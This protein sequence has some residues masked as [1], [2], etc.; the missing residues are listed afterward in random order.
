MAI[1]IYPVIG[2]QTDL[3]FYLSGIGISTPEYNLKRERGLISHQLF[4]TK[5]GTG[6]LIVDGKTFVQK[7]GSI[8][9]MS[10]KI[11]HEYIRATDDWETYWIVF[12]GKHLPELM[13]NLGFTSYVFNSC[14]SSDL[15]VT[16]FN[17]I[18]TAAKDPI[19]GDEKSSLLLYEYILYFKKILFSSQN[20]NTPSANILESAIIYMNTNFAS[21]I[22]LQ[23]LAD[24]SHISLQHFCRLFKAQ[25]GMRP[26]EYLTRRR[27]SEAKSLLETTDKPIEEIAKLSGYDDANYF[28]IVF[29]KLEGVSPS[30]Y[31]L[32]K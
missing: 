17:R 23:D 24:C 10:P 15:P 22:T 29:K 3:P 14:N 5:K 13:K 27:I 11:P 26:I 6:K 20:T 21:Y 9:Y 4:F 31:R 30:A 8:F 19:S 7:S 18:L 2:K 32:T 12:R 28:G 1:S 25:M 16:L